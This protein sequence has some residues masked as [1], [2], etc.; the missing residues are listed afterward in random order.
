MHLWY[1]SF[2]PPLEHHNMRSSRLAGLAL[3]AGVSSLSAQRSTISRD[4]FRSR[5]DS[6]V[7]TYLAESHA[8]AASFAVIRGNDTL[9]YGAYGL[10]N[11]DAARAPTATTIYEIGSNTKQ[12]TSAAIMK[13]VEQGRVKLDD[14][15]SKYVPQFPLHGH[16]VTIR[17]LLTHTSGIH[18]YTSSPE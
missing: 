10:A 4:A 15:L 12:F 6:L 14:D 18:D 7:L 16:K 1:A 17:Q 2:D 8:P 13:L 5:A 9:A 11:M 3:L